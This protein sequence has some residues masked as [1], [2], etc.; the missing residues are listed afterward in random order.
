MQL[1]LHVTQED[2]RPTNSSNYEATAQV[3]VSFQAEN[4]AYGD[5]VAS[6]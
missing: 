2:N 6:N 4:H 3:A 5:N 1:I